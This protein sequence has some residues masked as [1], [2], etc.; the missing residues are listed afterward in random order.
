MGLMYKACRN[1]S[2][3]INCSHDHRYDDVEGEDDHQC[4]EEDEVD[5]KGLYWQ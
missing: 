2:V 3:H 1:A 4:G 5:E